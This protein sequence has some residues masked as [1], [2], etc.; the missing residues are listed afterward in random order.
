MT[1]LLG[2]PRELEGETRALRSTPLSEAL[3]PTPARC[4]GALQGPEVSSGPSPLA[5]C[6]GATSDTCHQPLTAKTPTSPH[7]TPGLP[8]SSVPLTISSSWSI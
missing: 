5:L 1:A 4:R 6:P 2:I 7:V 8:L 3:C